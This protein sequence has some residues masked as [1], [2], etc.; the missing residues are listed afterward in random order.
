MK[1][2]LMAALAVGA[3]AFLGAC[4]KDSTSG[5]GGEPDTSNNVR[6]RITHPQ[7]TTSRTVADPMTGE[8][9]T[10]LEAGH[11]FFCNTAGVIVKHV[12]I[13]N[14]GWGS[15]DLTIDDILD[16]QAVVQDVPEW[17]GLYCVIVSGISNEDLGL[18]GRTDRDLEDENISTINNVQVPLSLLNNTNG[19]V[20]DVPMYGTGVV[21]RTAT[22]I[23]TEGLEEYDAAVSVRMYSVAA[24][25][26]IEKLTPIVYEDPINGFKATIDS[27]TVEGIYL[28][29]VYNNKGLSYQ[30][31]AIPGV[32]DANYITTSQDPL[33]YLP[34]STIYDADGIGFWMADNGMSTQ[35]LNADPTA[36]PS[37]FF[38]DEHVW[39]YNVHPS[40]Q[41]TVA[42]DDEYQDTDVPHVVVRFSEVTITIE[43]LD[44][45][46][47]I[48]IATT[49][50]NIAATGPQF[51]TLARY[52]FGAGD[53]NA[54][55]LITRFDKN[56]I[57]TLGDIRFNFDN[58]NPIPEADPMDVHV[59]VEMIPWTDHPIVWDNN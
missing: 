1:I 31:D 19:D 17:P 58:L 25:L 22:G 21:D 50:E 4:S 3:L 40:N 52:R 51:I 59:T 10:D 15:Q 48:D 44:P 18:D 47:D 43:D 57:Y 39:A 28:N 38:I 12:S 32:D 6:I 54:G 23:T 34:T 41:V 11:I 16:Q 33:F 26:Q 27:F 29:N 8:T 35:V 49:T 46:D 5:G 24:R 42:E 56:Q 37:S 13:D 36:D 14:A 30:V 55:D 45:D 20:T 7:N 53:D 2:K 9:P